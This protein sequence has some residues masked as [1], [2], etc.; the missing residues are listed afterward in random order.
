MPVELGHF[1]AKLPEGMN[2]RPK[3]RDEAMSDSAF[4]ARR[5]PSIAELLRIRFLNRW[6]F[7]GSK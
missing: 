2:L 1:P 7:H 3:F 6:G 5:M 4:G